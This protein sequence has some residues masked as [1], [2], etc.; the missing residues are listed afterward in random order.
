M[1]GHVTDIEGN[2]NVKVRLLDGD[3][4][5]FRAPS[6][7]VTRKGD[8]VTIDMTFGVPAPSALPR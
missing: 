6:G 8:P 4:F 5:E 1:Y 2:G 7:T 3:A